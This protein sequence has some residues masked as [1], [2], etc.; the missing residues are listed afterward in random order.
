MPPTWNA[1]PWLFDTLT[2]PLRTTVD[3]PFGPVI[4][5]LT[6]LMVS[7]PGSVSFMPTVP[8]SSDW[9]EPGSLPPE[10]LEQP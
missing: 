1:I 8:T 9:E 7:P 6:V 2:E 4:V 5:Q 10:P 3:A